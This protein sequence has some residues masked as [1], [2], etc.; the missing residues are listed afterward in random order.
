MGE[1]ADDIIDSYIDGFVDCWGSR[2]PRRA[3]GNYQSGTGNY[4]WRDTDGTLWDMRLM[5]Y[6]HLRN[7]LAV[8]ERKNNT[9][10][11]KQLREVMADMAAE[12]FTSE[13]KTQ[14]D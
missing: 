12:G 10:K 7:A 11:A 14:N 6:D 9:G 13:R 1:I 5:S 2:P 4:R 8:A 3:S